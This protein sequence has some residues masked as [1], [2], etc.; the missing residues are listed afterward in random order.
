MTSNRTKQGLAVMPAKER[1]LPGDGRGAGGDQ[2]ANERRHQER[3]ARKSSAKP[4]RQT[5]G[6]ESAAASQWDDADLD[7]E[8]ARRRAR[9][10]LSRSNSRFDRFG[11]RFS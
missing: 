10:L 1:S 4:H 6:P 8:V 9:R 5:Q 7:Q 11:D 2:S 3:M